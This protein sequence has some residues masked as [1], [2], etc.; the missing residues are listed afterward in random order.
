[1]ASNDVSSMAWI[2]KIRGLLK[3]KTLVGGCHIVFGAKTGGDL[4]CFGI[5]VIYPKRTFFNKSHLAANPALRYK[6]SPFNCC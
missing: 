3:N 4:F 5:E 6:K 1:M 2:K